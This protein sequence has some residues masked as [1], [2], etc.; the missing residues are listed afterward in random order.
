MWWLGTQRD[1]KEF[2]ITFDELSRGVAVVDATKGA[3]DRILVE[4]AVRA[5]VPVIVLDNTPDVMFTQLRNEKKK[6]ELKLSG[7]PQQIAKEFYSSVELGIFTPGNET[8]IPISIDPIAFFSMMQDLDAGFQESI[9]EAITYIIVSSFRNIDKVT[10]TS[11]FDPL[12]YV[13][14]DLF[15]RKVAITSLADLYNFFVENSDKLAVP[16]DQLETLTNNLSILAKGRKYTAYRQGILL[17]PQDLLVP[18]SEKSPV[19][20]INL[21]SIPDL[22]IRRN[23]LILL[24]IFLN[25]WVRKYKPEP[26]FLIF[27]NLT[28]QMSFKSSKSPGYEV[29]KDFVEQIIADKIGSVF[30]FSEHSALNQLILQYT[31]TQFIG[32]IEDDLILKKGTRTKYIADYTRVYDTLPNIQSEEFIVLKEDKKESSF[33]VRT[34]F[35]DSE[36]EAT[37]QFTDITSKNVLKYFNKLLV[38]PQKEEKAPTEL[39]EEVDLPL[40]VSSSLRLNVTTSKEVL[41]GRSIQEHN[42]IGDLGLSLLGANYEDTTWRGLPCYLDLSKPHLVFVAG[43]RGSGRNSTLRVILEGLNQCTVVDRIPFSTIILDSSHTFTSLNPIIEEKQLEILDRWGITPKRLSNVTVYLPQNDFT[44]L[45]TRE[46]GIIYKKL[47]IRPV[48]LGEEDWEYLLSSIAPLTGPMKNCLLDILRHFEQKGIINYSIGFMIHRIGTSSQLDDDY[49]SGTLN[50]LRNRLKILVATNLFSKEGI[51][52]NELIRP[53]QISILQM[54]SV[55]SSSIIEI[56]ASVLCQKI[57]RLI[58]QPRPQNLWLFLDRAHTLF[59][60]TKKTPIA[61]MIT[62]FCEIGPNRGLSLVLSSNQPA[63]ASNKLLSYMDIVLLHQMNPNAVK[64]L[65]THMPKSMPDAFKRETSSSISSFRPGV[66]CVFDRTPGNERGFAIKIR[67]PTMGRE[68]WFKPI[69]SRRID[70]SIPEGDL[71]DLSRSEID[72]IVESLP[73]ETGE[74]EDSTE[75][76]S[77]FTDVTKELGIEIIKEEKSSIKHK[78]VEEIK[79]QVKQVTPIWLKDITEV[80]ISVPSLSEIRESIKD[81]LRLEGTKNI[82]NI[83][84]HEVYAP[85]LI[86]EGRTV[87]AG[88]IPFPHDMNSMDSI[89]KRHFEVKAYNS[90]FLG[91]FSVLSDLDGQFQNYNFGKLQNN[92]YFIEMFRGLENYIRNARTEALDAT[93]TPRLSLEVPKKD[94]INEFK[95]NMNEFITMKSISHVVSTFVQEWE[96]EILPPIKNEISL[97]K[98]VRKVSVII[99]KATRESKNKKLERAEIT[100][101]LRKE[102]KKAT[103]A[104][105]DLKSRTRKLEKVINQLNQT[106]T[107][108]RQYLKELL[109]KIHQQGMDIRQTQEELVKRENFVQKTRN[110]IS[111]LQE[112]DKWIE[113]LRY[114]SKSLK[115]VQVMWTPFLFFSVLIENENQQT[116]FLGVSSPA[117]DVPPLFQCKICRK[118]TDKI[119]ICHE[120][121]QT[122]CDVHSITQCDKCKLS[123]CDSHLKKCEKEECELIICSNCGGIR[124]VGLLKKTERF[125]CKNH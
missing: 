53:G 23:F 72:S 96:K 65:S 108:A 118:V 99:A 85:V 106:E 17:N 119:V 12:F 68:S 60:K 74:A 94:V 16:P 43:A 92:I 102:K 18:K 30:S 34:S 3:L 40:A 42:E 26:F 37:G 110:N 111:S 87:A 13:L 83:E 86:L 35:S 78:R 27:S 104:A 93:D 36:R 98:K 50:G 41:I 62:R 105:Q 29:W 79:E 22:K 32:K 64:Q 80:T 63:A 115:K 49:T 66:S 45:R 113:S 9:I 114:L 55:V 10:R 56:A 20:I 25:I 46:E 67:P 117:C 103:K 82:A 44:Q 58:R 89:E 122:A 15:R 48:D 107:D 1:R 101:Q 97:L 38:P 116:T 57:L 109:R 6:E 54:S 125:Y 120:C 121:L 100:K 73:S 75:I 81:N 71:G 123:F 76:A 28:S 39:L 69:I 124:K 19:S 51:L 31:T 8:G 5:R 24:V 47:T 52:I 95:K 2:T 61:N 70:Q 4:E 91:N 84:F 11:L 14:Y 33:V 88:E 112:D 59:P 77:I 7:I 90:V 21:S